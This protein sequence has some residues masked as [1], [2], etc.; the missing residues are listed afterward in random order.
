[1]GFRTSLGL[2]GCL[3]LTLAGPLQ[4]QD[5]EQFR[6]RLS[7]L[8]VD[9]RTVPTVSGWGEVAAVL[10][11]HELAITATF[12]GMSSP[13][14]AAH[15][16]RARRGLHGAVAFAIEVAGVTDGTIEDTVTLTETQRRE[17]RDGLFYVQIH[18]EGNTGGELRGWLLPR[19]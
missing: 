15:V 19:P 16:H 2:L 4:A 5:R 1:M 12:E 13:A 14:I 6:D 3:W 7:P 11:G 17:L 10:D 18:T 9:R 8:P